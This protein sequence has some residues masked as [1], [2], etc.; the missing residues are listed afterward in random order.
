MVKNIVEYVWLDGKNNFRKKTKI[1]ESDNLSFNDL[2]SWNYDGS[3]TYQASGN[4]SEVIIIPRQL[5]PYKNCIN[6]IKKY[7]TICDTWLTNGTAH[8]TNTRDNAE[9]IFNKDYDLKPWFGIEQE[10]FFIDPMT[11][12]PLGF[13]QNGSAHPQG[14]YYCSVGSSNCFGRKIAD[15]C[16]NNCLI[17]GLN[18][19]GLNFEVAP[20]Q[21]EIQL[22][23]EGIKAADDLL[24]MRYIITRTSE[25]FGVNVDFSAK[26]LKG[27]WNG[28]GCHVNFSTLPMRSENGL[29][30]IMKSIKKLE[31]THIEH[32]EAYGDD[33]YLRLTGSH[34]TSSLEKFSYGVANRGCSIRIPNE[35][36][37]N[38]KGY[39]E[40][41][42]PSSSMDPYKVLSLL[43]NTSCFS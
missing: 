36:Q 4:N 27:D 25:E 12:L 17:A 9:N 7:L 20:G 28:S 41:R 6:N 8:E 35:T 19:T 22:R 3:S 34:E 13:N 16:L 29:L 15:E 37:I 1:I 2:P 30:E 10:F 31:S 32:I 26:P 21:C 5:Y 14:Q 40:D 42:R 23:E 38:K 39:F 33:N 43:F 11:N 18:V 24:I